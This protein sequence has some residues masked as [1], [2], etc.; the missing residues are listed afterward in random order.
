MDMAGDDA[1]EGATAAMAK[2]KVAG[3]EALKSADLPLAIECYE[4]AIRL[5]EPALA[6]VPQPKLLRDNDLVRYHENKFGKVDTAR[7]AFDEYWVMDLGTRELVKFQTGMHTEVEKSFKR[8]ELVSV[9]QDLLDLRL[10]CLQNLTLVSLKFARASKKACDF[11]ETARRAEAALAMD[12]CSAKALLRKGYALLELECIEAAGHV[13]ARAYQVTLGK[14]Q[15]V[16]ELL[17]VVAELKGKAKGKGTGKGRNGIKGKGGPVQYDDGA[18]PYTPP[19]APTDSG[20][21]DSEEDR[22][23]RSEQEEHGTSADPLPK[24]CRGSAEPQRSA[25]P[26]GKGGKGSASEKQLEG[27]PVHSVGAARRWSLSLILILAMVAFIIVG[28]VIMLS[29]SPTSRSDL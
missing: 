11:E 3:N 17:R 2:S 4:E 16:I 8:K 23:S 6:L 9:P 27:K 21:S 18:E 7:H 14:D 13:L 12:G 10:A 20:A 22:V 25:E 5:F 26:I 29:W 15:E 1:L 19:R 28:N 24:D